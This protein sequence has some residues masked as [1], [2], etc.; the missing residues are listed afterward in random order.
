M[1]PWARRKRRGDDRQRARRH[2]GA[3][4]TLHR[5]S[6]DEHST[7]RRGAAGQR[8]QRE[9]NQRRDERPAL[10]EVIGRAATEHQEA[11]ERD[12]IGVDNPLQVGRGEP[13]ARLDRGQRDVD[14]AQ[15]EDD[16]EL[17]HAA[18]GQQPR[19]TR[20]LLALGRR[21]RPRARRR[22]DAH[23][24]LSNCDWRCKRLVG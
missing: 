23:D 7:A 18:N 16:H 1:K 10:P 11:R 8:G 2:E 17:G 3:A 12:H 22:L 5:A 14:D 19:R 9:Q 21:C 24:G 13:K 15:V 20:A 4:E 6:A